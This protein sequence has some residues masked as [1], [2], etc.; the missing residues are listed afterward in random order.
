MEL[1]VSIL[2]AL[3]RKEMI[4]TLNKTSVSYIHIDFMDGKFVSNKEYSIEEVKQL[5]KYSHKKLDIHLMV[6]NPMD[7]IENLKDINN[8][9]NI[10]IHLEIDDD[11]KKILLKIREYGFKAG[12]SIKPNTSVQKISEYLEYLDL[13]LVMSVEPGLGG[14]TF[15]DNTVYKINDIKKL[16][17]NDDIKIEV[18]G[19]INKDTIGKVLNADILVM[20]SYIT[21][22]DNPIDVIND[23]LV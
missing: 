23:L 4:E 13:I 9:E 12:L 7:Y 1:S 14:Q 3:D 18:D 11:I 16:I 5:A 6:E 17:G 15:L 2:N 10:T 22:S 8:I 21:K 20:G 19:G